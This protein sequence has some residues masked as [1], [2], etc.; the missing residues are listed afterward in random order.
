MELHIFISF[1]LG[2]LNL[3]GFDIQNN[4]RSYNL[5]LLHENNNLNIQLTAH[6]THQIKYRDTII[7]L[8]YFP[9]CTISGI[10]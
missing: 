8:A 4:S 9:E 2:Q 1:K 7:L 10:T 5:L 3:S 6:L